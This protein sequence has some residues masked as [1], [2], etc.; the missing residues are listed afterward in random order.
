[1]RWLLM[2]FSS[3][4]GKKQIMAVTGLCFCLFL[5]THLA[6]NFT[7][8]GGREMLNAYSA[9]LHAFGL[10]INAIEVGLLV[11]AVLHVFLATTLYIQNLY[12]RP[13]RYAV[14]RNAGG[15]TLSSFLMPYT[16]LYLAVFVGIHLLTFHFADRTNRSLSQ[17]V[18][19]V[20]SSPFYVVFYVFSVI[21]AGLHVK[22]GLW[23]AFQTIGADHP[24]YTPL[25][26][27]ASLI[28]SLIVGAG[29]GSIPLFV[30]AGT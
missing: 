22:H 21:V 7:I 30:M 9:R 26:R 16:G 29:F 14:K 24:K 12:A 28:F 5:A 15:R 2:T 6:G 11:L 23:S 18:E 8:Y 17:L 4:I 20:F 25:I 1:M 3:S 19:D 13:N 10:L 27:W